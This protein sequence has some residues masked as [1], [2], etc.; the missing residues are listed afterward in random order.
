M[1]P[2]IQTTKVVDVEVW[3]HGKQREDDKMTEKNDYNDY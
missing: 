3:R 2:I 1:T